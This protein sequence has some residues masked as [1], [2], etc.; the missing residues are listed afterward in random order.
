LFISRI[1]WQPDYLDLALKLREAE[2]AGGS[3]A[4]ERAAIDALIA[5]HPN[6]GTMLD[7]GFGR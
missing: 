2:L 5:K 7:R 3:G 1:A 6:D 4:N